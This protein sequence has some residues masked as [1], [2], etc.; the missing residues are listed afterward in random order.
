[1][2]TIERIMML[3]RRKIKRV[4]TCL[5]CL[6]ALL[7]LYFI[8][9]PRR[10]EIPDEIPD[11]KDF[12]F[13][14]ILPFI[15]PELTIEERSLYMAVIVN[16]AAAGEKHRGLRSAIRSTWGKNLL[17]PTDQNDYNWKVFY[18]LGLA[19]NYGDNF[20]NRLEAKQHNDVLIGNFTDHYYNIATKTFMGHF[21]VLKRL[22][23][24]YVLKTD[25]DV[26]VRVPQT[27]QWLETQGSPGRFYGG[28]VERKKLD[29]IRDVTDKW[30]ITREQYDGVIWP[31]YCH[32]AFHVLSD[33]AVSIIVDHSRHKKPP[34][35][36]DAYIAVIMLNASIPATPIP[37]YYVFR[38]YKFDCDLL[39]VRATG[40]KLSA[41]DIVNYHRFYENYDEEDVR[42][43][44]SFGIY[45]KFI[46]KY[47]PIL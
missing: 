47:L 32:G 16:T 24:R 17:K 26:Y 29:V 9:K 3:P 22:K 18:V 23:V 45:R 36:D 37:G 46:S 34:F 28:Y 8:I 40:H 31:R 25:D 35:T 41:R 13:S 43:K 38:N 6:S 44:C 15:E 5:F 7:I 30:Y 27:I 1:M 11:R 10:K 42:W 12:N 21:W 20:Q 19:K 39:K 4:F 33:D 14:L 2:L